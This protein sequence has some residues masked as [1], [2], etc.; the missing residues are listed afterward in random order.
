M[1]TQPVVVRL[2]STVG[3]SHGEHSITGFA[4]SCEDVAELCYDMMVQAYGPKCLFGNRPRHL[5]HVLDEPVPTSNPLL[6]SALLCVTFVRQMCDFDVF[7]GIVGLNRCA[8]SGQPK[9]KHSRQLSSTLNTCVHTIKIYL[10]EMA[11]K[12]GGLSG[13]HAQFT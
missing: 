1:H 11:W 2:E 6:N 13:K 12:W 9:G 10:Y 7:L 4:S 8:F 3:E 5:A